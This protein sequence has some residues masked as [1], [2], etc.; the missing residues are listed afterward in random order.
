[1]LLLKNKKN[2]INFTTMHETTRQ[3]MD[4]LAD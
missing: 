4:L 1:M 2:I 3:M